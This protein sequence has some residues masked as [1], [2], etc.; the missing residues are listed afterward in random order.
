MR[1]QWT[2]QEAEPGL[3]IELALQQRL[4]VSDLLFPEKGT[5]E[6]FSWCSS[7]PL[8][9]TRAKAEAWLSLL[10]NASTADSCF[11]SRL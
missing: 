8:L 5:A 6:N 7:W 11:L 4:W 9:L 1:T 3:L 2:V 10:G